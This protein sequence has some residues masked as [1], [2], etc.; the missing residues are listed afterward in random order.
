MNNLSSKERRIILIS[1]L[2][3]STG[4]LFQNC[5]KKLA[6]QALLAPQTSIID[7]AGNLPD[8]PKKEDVNPKILNC[9]IPA[10]R[11]S[12]LKE[13]CLPKALERIAQIGELDNFTEFQPQYPL[14]S[15]GATKK[16][17]IYLPTGTK[18]D[19]SNPDHWIYPKG[20]IV[21]KEFSMDGQMIET[22]MIEKIAD[23]DGSSAWRFSIFANRKDDTDADRLDNADL[24]LQTE[25]LATY[26]ASDFST[27]YNIGSFN[28]CTNCHGRSKDV[29]NGFSYLQLSSPSLAVNINSVSAKN[30]LTVPPL[31]FDEIPGNTTHQLAVGY[32][33]SNC[34]TCHDGSGGIGPGDFRHLST[35]VSYTNEP[36]YAT[37]STRTGLIVPGNA[38]TSR[39]FQRINLDRS[40]PSAMPKIPLFNKDSIGVSA[41]EAWINQL[42]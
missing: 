22:R 15:D 16:R 11:Y 38:A 17:W 1:I 36:L 33:Q 39:L 21:F 19:T 25:L 20:T 42:Q 9:D 3:S 23:G 32:M 29:V 28:T 4:L 2:L 37:Q 24:H 34:A 41:I 27:R 13:T 10:V 7:P 31:R 12:T 8:S 26:K 18:I 5:N 6:S 40:V 14:Y 30:W 35:S